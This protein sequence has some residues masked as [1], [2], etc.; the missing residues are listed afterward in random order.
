MGVVTAE[1]IILLN[2]IGMMEIA[3]ILTIGMEGTTVLW[4]ILG[5]LVMV[6]AT[7]MPMV[8]ILNLVAGTEGTVLQKIIRSASSITHMRISMRMENHF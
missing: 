1:Y 5:G 6:F 7:E 2:A 8:T 3:K 4:R